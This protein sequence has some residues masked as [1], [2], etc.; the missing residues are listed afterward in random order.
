LG[1]TTKGAKK[2]FARRMTF[3]I[4]PYLGNKYSR[5]PFAC[6]YLWIFWQNNI[7]RWK[8]TWLL[9]GFWKQTWLLAIMVYKYVFLSH[10][11]HLFQFGWRLCQICHNKNT[12]HCISI[13][14]KTGI[15]SYNLICLILHRTSVQNI[16]TQTTNK[17]YKKP[18]TWPA[19]TLSALS[20]G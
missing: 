8:Q 10:V 17:H 2:K 15:S 1:I 19:S 16:V 5:L 7:I 9:D 3:V 20:P 4:A 12:L 11:I 14:H 18:A 13:H 6:K